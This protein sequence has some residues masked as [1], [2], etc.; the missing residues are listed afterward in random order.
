MWEVFDGAMVIAWIVGAYFA[1]A[2]LLASRLG[3]IISRADRAEAEPAED[4]AATDSLRDRAERADARR[5][6][7]RPGTAC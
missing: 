6:A 4:H 7:R 1:C 5:C 2:L 3:G